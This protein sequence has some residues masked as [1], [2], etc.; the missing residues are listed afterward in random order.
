MNRREQRAWHG[1]KNEDE[2]QFDLFPQTAL[3]AKP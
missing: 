3:E 2:N 1:R